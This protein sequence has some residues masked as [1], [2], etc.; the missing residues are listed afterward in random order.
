MR[1]AAELRLL[2]A[3]KASSAAMAEELQKQAAQ[4]EVVMEKL[5]TEVR[6]QQLWCRLGG[7]LSGSGGPAVVSTMPIHSTIR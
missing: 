5:R 6:F 7:G 1:T 3:D 2:D 4:F